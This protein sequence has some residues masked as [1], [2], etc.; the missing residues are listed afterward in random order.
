MG[1][2]LTVADIEGWREW[3]RNNVNAN[4][5]TDWERVHKDMNT[6]CDLALSALAS[7]WRPISDAPKDGRL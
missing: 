5:R 6:L 4:N 1:G 2:E 3:L 7:R